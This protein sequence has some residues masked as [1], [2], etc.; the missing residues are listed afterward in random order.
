MIKI[1][2]ESK[3]PTKK[4]ESLEQVTQDVI[5]ELNDELLKQRVMSG[6]YQDH[7]NE[8]LGKKI[9]TYGADAAAE[10]VDSSTGLL[11]AALAGAVGGLFVPVVGPV[12][13]FFTGIGVYT[14]SKVWKVYRRVKR[15]KNLEIK[16]K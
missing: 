15:K 6:N 5:G 14:G 10:I 11:G 4:G 7:S 8:S 9:A 12:A 13:G 2:P 3:K 16:I 1:T